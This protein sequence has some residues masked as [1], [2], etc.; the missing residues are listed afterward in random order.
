MCVCMCVCVY[1]YMEE[2]RARE[3][4]HNSYMYGLPIWSKKESKRTPK[5]PKCPK[6]KGGPSHWLEWPSSKKSTTINTGEDVKEREP[7]YTVGRNA[8]WHSHY[9]GEYGGSLKKLKM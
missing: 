3:S 6:E 5:V 9:L 2:G 4:C 1:I 7:S 8:N